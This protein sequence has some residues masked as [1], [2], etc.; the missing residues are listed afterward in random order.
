MKKEYP[1][2]LK[3]IKRWIDVGEELSKERDKPATHE[4][5]EPTF[6]EIQE[7]KVKENF[8]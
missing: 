1:Q 2:F 4:H 8:N 3:D 5:H 7:D 6:K